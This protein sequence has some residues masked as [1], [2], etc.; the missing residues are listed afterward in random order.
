MIKTTYAIIFKK[1]F[2]ELVWD[3]FIE[4]TTIHNTGNFLYSDDGG[5]F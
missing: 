4:F 1:Y 2:D 5:N 3:L